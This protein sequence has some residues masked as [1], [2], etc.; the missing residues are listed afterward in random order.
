MTK[1]VFDVIFAAIGIV[2]LLPLLIVTGLAVLFTSRGPVFYVQSRVGRHNTDFRLYKF[3]TMYAGESSKS[4]LTIG[5]RDSR[6]TKVG[7]WLRKYKIDELPQL[8]NVLLGDMS[9]VG[10]RPEVRKYVDMYDVQQQRVL[11]V[12]PGITDWASI[13][14]RD[15]SQLLST[16]DDPEHFYITE[17]IPSKLHSNLKYIDHHNLIVDLR[18]II[19]TVQK[20]LFGGRSLN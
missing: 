11:S 20:V 1:R 6:I 10:P 8:V 7:Y 5:D 15:E 18:I 19:S 17:I 14:F 13:H 9:L 12:R 3:R 4:L 2:A 16:A